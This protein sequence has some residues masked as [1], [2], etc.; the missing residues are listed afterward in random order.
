MQLNG[1]L[2]EFFNIG[3]GCRQGDPISPYLFILCAEILSIK[4]RNNRN[5][6]GICINGIEYKI[7]Q[8]AY[9]T[10]LLLDGSE[11]TVNKTIDILYHFSQFSGLKINFEKT[12]VIWIGSLK[13]STLSIKTKW[14]LDWGN[15]NFKLLGI[16]FTMT[17]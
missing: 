8:F 6:K 4:I 15:N 2:S 12:N 16:Q 9:D 3:R 5:I 17:W 1:F 10:T 14:K 11:D 7:S 13:Y